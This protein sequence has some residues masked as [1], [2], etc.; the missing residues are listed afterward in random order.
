MLLAGKTLHQKE[1][2]LSGPLGQPKLVL[3]TIVP[4]PMQPTQAIGLIRKEMYS[5]ENVTDKNIR[6][7]G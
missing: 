1:L 4:W 6:R 5:E 2:L 7:L 3:L